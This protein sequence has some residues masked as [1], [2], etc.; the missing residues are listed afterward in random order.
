MTQERLRNAEISEQLMHAYTMLIV[1]FN[2]S[3]LNT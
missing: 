1:L 3:E 2:Q